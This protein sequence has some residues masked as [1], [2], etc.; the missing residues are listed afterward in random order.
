M[1]NITRT[2]ADALIETQVANEIFEGVVKESKAL[3]MFR[4]LPNMTSDKT[5]LRVLDSLPIA[6]FV[7]ETKNNGRKNLTKMAWDKKYIN[8]AELAVIVPIKENVLN[9]FNTFTKSIPE[10]TFEKE[11]NRWKK[12]P[13]YDLNQIED[14]L[15][16]R[17]PI[18]DKNMYELYTIEPNITIKYSTN[19]KTLFP[20]EVTLIP[21]R[22]DIRIL[23]NNKLTYDYTYTF[24]NNNEYTFEYQDWYNNVKTDTIKV[25]WIINSKLIYLSVS[26][27]IILITSMLISIKQKK[28][29][30]NKKNSKK[31]KS[32]KTSPSRNKKT[33]KKNSKKHSTSKK[34]KKKRS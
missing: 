9:E 10:Q 18:I 1:S 12:I 3:S 19:K 24:K 26:I 29:T 32:K 2:D 5:K 30:P 27:I 6:Y 20:V 31:S 8:A 23:K 14:F 22:T 13:G 4:R 28:P 15:N 17:I 16:T 25:D 11:N 34:K 33:T 21:N 7:D